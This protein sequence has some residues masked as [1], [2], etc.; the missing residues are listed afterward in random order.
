MCKTLRDG[1]LKPQNF[2]PFARD[3]LRNFLLIPNEGR[4]LPQQSIRPSLYGRKQ[5]K[6]SLVSAF[7][8]V[9]VVASVAFAQNRACSLTSLS[10]R[11]GSGQ[12]GGF[13]GRVVHRKEGAWAKALNSLVSARISVPK[14]NSRH[15]RCALIMTDHL[16][17]LSR[18]TRAFSLSHALAEGTAARSA[19][20]CM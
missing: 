10:R 11:C 6:A 8:L 13:Q 9:S 2:H 19:I 16:R 14:S 20:R 12:T 3:A 15:T 1:S 7:H 5:L 18:A 4:R 17:C